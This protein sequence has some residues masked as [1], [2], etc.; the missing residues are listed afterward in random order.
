MYCTASDFKTKSKY[1]SFTNENF[2]VFF[3]INT[4]QFLRF[5]LQFRCA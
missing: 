4:F 2:T 5:D 1:S 3:I